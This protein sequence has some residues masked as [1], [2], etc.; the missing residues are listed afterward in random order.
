[1]AGKVI[2]TAEQIF[3]HH[4]ISIYLRPTQTSSA[5]GFHSHEFTEIAVLFHGSA[6]YST[7]FGSQEIR[8][9]DV[10]V[11]PAKKPHAVF[12]KEDFK[13]LLTVVFPLD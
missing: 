10:L 4:D 1:M 6:L 9:G 12:A 2:L 13:M 11:M 7:Q 8:A 5:L 3:G